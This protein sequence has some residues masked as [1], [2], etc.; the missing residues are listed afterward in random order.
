MAVI[1]QFVVKNQ[2]S[3]GSFPKGGTPNASYYVQRAQPLLKMMA[4]Q[5]AKQEFEE[6]RRTNIE[7]IL[8]QVRQSE[9]EAQKANS[10]QGI[11][12]NTITGIPN[13]IGQIGN[14]IRTNPLDTLKSIGSG[15]YKGAV[16]P[17]ANIQKYTNPAMLI[18]Q[19]RESQKKA[20]EMMNYQ[21]QNDVSRS[22]QSGFEFGGAVA[23]YEIAGQAI[24][25]IPQL[26]NTPRLAK[27]IGYTVPGQIF[28]D[29]K[30]TDVK[31]RG[32]QL[33]LDSLLFGLT[34]LRGRKSPSQAELT[35]GKTI[36]GRQGSLPQGRV[37]EGQISN[38][39][40]PE[41]GKYASPET[42][43]NNGKIPA[44]RTMPELM[45]SNKGPAK[46]ILS[47]G[48]VET[49]YP[50]GSID[51]NIKQ[52][53]INKV[54]E[55]L[56]GAKSLQG[57]Q[58]SLYKAERARRA[59]AI[60]GIGKNVPGEKGYFAQLG[61]LKGELPKVNFEGIRTSLN[62]SDVD[63]LFNHVENHRLLTPF[64]KI[65][66]KG[67][68][69]KIMGE[70]GGQ[71]PTKGEIRLLS[72]VFPKE[73]IDTIL[74]KRPWGQK[75]LDKAG[76]ALNIPRSLMA[77]F[78]LSAPLRQGV[79]LIGKPKQWGPAFKDMFKH[80]FSEKSY[81]GLLENIQTRPT[82][83]LMRESKLAITDM[84][85]FMDKREERF[86]SNWAE[87]I[88]GIGKIVRGS[89]RAYTGFLN[90]L[91]ADVFDDLVN[92]LGKEQAGDIAKF[93][94]S[95][96]GRGELPQVL[97]NS[98]ALLNGAFFSPR[99][100]F[101][102]INMMNPQYYV[103]L[104]PAVRKEAIKSLLTF[105]GT[106]A[107][108]LGLA[109][110][111]G[112]EIGTDARSAGFAKIKTGNTRYDILGGFQQYAVLAYRLATNEMV[113]STTGKEF[114]LDEGYKAP[115]RLGIIGRFLSSKESPIVGF[116]AGM[117]SGQD[118]MGQE[119]RPTP[120]IINR[121]IP[122]LIQD[123]TDT[124]GEYGTEKGALMQSP[125]VF[126]V[127]TQTYTDQIPVLEK[128]PTGAP[129]VKFNPYPSIGEKIQNS[130][131]GTEISQIPQDQWEG[132]RQERAMETQRGLEVEKI[133]Q[134]VLS[135]GKPER[136]G[137]TFVYMQN[138]IVKTKK[139]GNQIRTPIKDKIL[140]QEIQKRK[141]TPFYQ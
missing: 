83:Q 86:M 107:S 44:S 23:P 22:I 136:V 134:K 13:A 77:S 21:P 104:S 103:S 124:M 15:V 11:V 70:E 25:R 114:S 58:T 30:I 121:F 119:F 76:E 80:A 138:G 96:T 52:D 113:S 128:T 127:G 57:Q 51:G 137:D 131:T 65:S 129:T 99:L 95:A 108:V 75:F 115:G 60:A 38:L 36:P 55:A 50:I 109:G 92:K 82:Y 41:S 71:L 116:V 90:K 69:A 6:K 9:Q 37:P 122:M 63:S 110:L 84:S 67:G 14:Q 39:P 12:K 3:G 62:Q 105:G 46:E 130:I 10:W 35:T 101:S 73:F 34:S 98:Q 16:E 54:I 32:E 140:Y 126:G 64:E 106:V 1:K 118:S 120:E 102:R 43:Q 24:S 47:G 112:A 123:L 27:Y 132:L 100:M 28:S 135:T 2:A 45:N 117:L 4:V 88:P 17:L 61:Q 72:E 26:A 19:V 40:Y 79:F 85:K 59:G 66:A 111:S 18:P 87:Q 78:D 93:V 133:K 20:S 29:K 5:R 49:S 33:A 141:T 74:E 7:N 89:D 94:N 97:K 68:L 125:G 53:P 48:Q 42:F 56:K 31:G 81:Q 91:R 8:N 139:I